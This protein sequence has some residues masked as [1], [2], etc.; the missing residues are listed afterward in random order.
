[1]ESRVFSVYIEIITGKT[2]Y[3]FICLLDFLYISSVVHS[4]FISS[5]LIL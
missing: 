1:M 4:D 2:E 5:F 3:L